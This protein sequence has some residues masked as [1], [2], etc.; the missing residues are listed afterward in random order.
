MVL[1]VK[2]IYNCGMNGVS[3]RENME[4]LKVFVNAKKIASG[5]YLVE[6]HFRLFDHH[7]YYTANIVDSIVINGKEV[8][9]DKIFTTA[10][11]LVWIVDND[12]RICCITAKKN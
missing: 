6:A 2:R 12:K 10:D 9:D 11:T 7:E 1:F 3:M 8:E 4:W 5:K